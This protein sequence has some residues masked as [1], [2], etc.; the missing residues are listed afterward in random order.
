VP[1]S[2]SFR[3]KLYGCLI[4]SLLKCHKAKDPFRAKIKIIQKKLVQLFDYNALLPFVPERETRLPT[5][6][7]KLSEPWKRKRAALKQRAGLAC[8]FRRDC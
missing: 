6:I 7:R 1:R 2:K 3:R 4:D 8:G 5:H